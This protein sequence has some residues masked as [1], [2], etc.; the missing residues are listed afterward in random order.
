M[1]A[2]RAAAA[3]RWSAVKSALKK[4]GIGRL[5]HRLGRQHHGLQSA[6][7]DQAVDYTGAHPGLA[8]GVGLAAHHAVGQQRQHAP[9]RAGQ[10]F[11]RR[12]V[13]PHAEPLAF[14]AEMLA[15]AQ[16]HAQHHAAR[17]ERVICH[18]IDE[19]A[20]LG[21]ER[22]E[23]QLLLDVFE[24]VIEARIGLGVLGPHDAGGFA[25]PERHGHNIARGELKLRRRAIGIGPVQRDRHQHVHDPFRHLVPDSEAIVRRFS[26]I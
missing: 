15:H 11:G 9:A 16:A 26:P 12:A 25:R 1:V 8:R 22:R 23:L 17:A 10:P 7:V 3:A 24:P 21:L 2:C 4:I 13:K 14:G 18:P 6:F 19:A 20:Q 5:R